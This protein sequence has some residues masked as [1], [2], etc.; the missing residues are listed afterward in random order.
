VPSVAKLI[1]GTLRG[2]QFSSMPDWLG[3]SIFAAMMLLFIVA[4]VRAILEQR[5]LRRRSIVEW[6]EYPNNHHVLGVGYYHATDRR[7]HV[8]PWN[9]F[10]EDRGYYWD[11][12]WHDTPDV[13]QV[14]SSVPDA[15]EILRVNEA[16]RKAG[17]TTAANFWA[18]VDRNGFGTA[19]G[20]RQGS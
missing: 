14:A 19:I 18:E 8:S 6:K 12:A 17:P 15:D 7:W 1:A 20:R 3:F 9:E 10:R 13:R 11:G 16:W 2:A 5:E 4:Q